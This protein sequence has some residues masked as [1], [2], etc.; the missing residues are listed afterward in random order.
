[1]LDQKFKIHT[2]GC[3]VNTY[4]SGLLFNQ[5]KGQDQDWHNSVHVINS[6][7]VTQEATK[8]AVR[9]A[10]KIKAKN[11]LAVV[12]ATGCAAQVDSEQLVAS[13]A[14][15]LVVANSHKSQISELINQHFKRTLTAKLF[16]SNIFK[17]EDLEAGGGVEPSHRRA[18]LK[19]QDGCNSFCSF[20]IIPY[21]RGLSRSISIK[22]LVQRVV[23]LH[24]SGI[25]EVV[26][27]G[28]HIGDYADDTLSLASP[29][30]LEDLVAQILLQTKIP[31][32]RLSS[33][34]PIEVTDQL[35]SLFKNERLCPHFHMSIQSAS[36]EVLHQ[37]KRKYTSQEVKSSLIRIRS[38]LPHAFIGMDVIAGFPTETD[39][40][41]LETYQILAESPWTKLHVFPYSERPGTKGAL[42][43]QMPMSIRKARAMRLRDLSNQRY[44]SEALKQI[45]LQ[46]KALIIGAEGKGF[47]GLTS[48]YWNCEFIDLADHQVAKLLNLEVKV[49]VMDYHPPTPRHKEGHLLVKLADDQLLQGL[50]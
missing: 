2:F 40:Q 44:H 8:E 10:R 19:I 36:T 39:E 25:Q 15:D 5:I 6:C 50:L 29:K 11:P 22:D 41:F 1:M 3:K 49:Q 32:I 43:P 37:M 33:L 17:K 18:F 34:E 30:K 48:S 16:K 45:G 13:P 27:T 14:I 4:D 24:S 35:L 7:A 28:V 26:L 21:A 31:R 47:W 46:K 20:C 9:L 23:E 12:V 38:Q 42:L